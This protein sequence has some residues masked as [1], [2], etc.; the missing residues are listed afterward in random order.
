MG[1]V[2]G[3]GCVEEVRIDLTFVLVFTSSYIFHFWSLLHLLFLSHIRL[4]FL[5][6]FLFELS[7]LAYSPDAFLF[8]LFLYY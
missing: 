4:L 3:S 5:F 6:L 7:F 1:R 2:L 8:S